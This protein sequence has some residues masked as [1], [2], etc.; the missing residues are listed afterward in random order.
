MVIHNQ[1]NYEWVAGLAEPHQKVTLWL[2]IRKKSQIK[3]LELRLKQ[4]Q[5]GSFDFKHIQNL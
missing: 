1:Q 3:Q 2:K 5:N 4:G